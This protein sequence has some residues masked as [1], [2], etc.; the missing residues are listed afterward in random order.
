MRI[1]VVTSLLLISTI[2]LPAQPAAGLYHRAVIRQTGELGVRFESGLTVCDEALR[3][4]HWVN[5]YW[6]STGM[7]KPEFH[8]EGE[9]RVF[10]GLPLD[11]FELSLEGQDLGGSWQW[12]KATQTEVHNP[13]GLLVTVQLKSKAKPITVKVQTLLHGGPVMIRWLEVTNTG[14]SATGLTSVSPWSGMIW[15][16][17]GYVERLKTGEAVFEVGH[18]QYEEWGHEGAWKFDPVVNNAVTVNGT[19][20]KS[21]WGHPT[22]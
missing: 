10:E 4:G 19:R 16:T 9:R 8:L 22:F 11:A 13:E 18:A 12:V 3:N 21:G 15:N 5:R 1:A 6:L 20:G 2:S 7:V 14:T 17:P